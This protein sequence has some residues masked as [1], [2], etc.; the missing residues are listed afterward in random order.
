VNE[1]SR[2][3]DALKEFL[4]DAIDRIDTNRI[5]L[6]VDE[7]VANI[8]E[9]AYQVP[10]GL[11]DTRPAATSVE[12]RTIDLTMQRDARS[13]RFVLEDRGPVFDPTRLPPPNMEEHS[14]SSNEGGLGVFLYMTLMDEA[15]HEPRDGGGN[16][17]ILEKAL[18]ARGN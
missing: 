18:P 13:V 17:L 14:K 1:L 3:R 2:V 7:A 16:R 6:S 15:R 11:P 10:E 5:I 8:V 9:H 12:D 4:G